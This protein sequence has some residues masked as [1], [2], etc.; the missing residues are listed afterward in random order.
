MQI[1]FAAWFVAVNAACSSTALQSSET[2]A[3][4]P[5]AAV[6]VTKSGKK[7][8]AASCP[9]VRRSKTIKPI[10]KNAAIAAGYTDCKVCQP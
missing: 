6:Y 5:S 3:P 10:T 7:Y 9:T 8:H 1:F 4:K 2:A